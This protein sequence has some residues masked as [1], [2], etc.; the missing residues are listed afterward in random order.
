M[1][2]RSQDGTA[3]LGHG[4]WQTFF[5][6]RQQ[7]SWGVSG[8]E[9]GPEKEGDASRLT[10]TPVLSQV[11]RDHFTPAVVPTQTQDISVVVIIIII[12][13]LQMGELRLREEKRLACCGRQNE[14]PQR[15][16]CPNSRTCE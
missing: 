13:V 12:S 8:Q 9:L 16:S 5:P 6:K 2:A 11:L 7:F 3:K 4:L 10:P 1:E 14:G 15:C